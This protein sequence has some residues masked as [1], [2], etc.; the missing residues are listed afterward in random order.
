MTAA[1]DP[2]TPERISWASVPVPWS[3]SSTLLDRAADVNLRIKDD[4][5]AD[6]VEQLALLVIEK[7]ERI[8]AM[9]QVISAALEELHQ[10][11]CAKDHL[12]DRLIELRRQT[13]ARTVPIRRQLKVKRRKGQDEEQ[14]QDQGQ[15]QGQGQ[16]QG[17]ARWT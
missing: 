5:V 9:G 10:L 1:R 12:S 15:T 13:G 14:R 4:V 3:D 8:E 17:Q 6:L 16:G 2:V 7:D 11:Q